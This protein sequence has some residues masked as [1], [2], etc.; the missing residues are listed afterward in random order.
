MNTYKETYSLTKQ[1]DE[2]EKYIEKVVNDYQLT[3]LESFELRIHTAYNR[4]MLELNQ[5]KKDILSW[6]QNLKP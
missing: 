4:A 6:T 5:I 1:S 3:P 2:L